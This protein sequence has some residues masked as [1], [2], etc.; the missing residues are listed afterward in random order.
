MLLTAEQSL[1]Y[2]L[3]PLLATTDADEVSEETPPLF[4]RSSQ[5]SHI[6]FSMIARTLVAST[7][8]TLFNAAARPVAVPALAGVARRAYHAKVVDH[9]ENPRYALRRLGYTALTL[10]AGT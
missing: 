3:T 10:H 9:Y 6:N 2:L 5:D 7:S 1:K 4:S 8:K